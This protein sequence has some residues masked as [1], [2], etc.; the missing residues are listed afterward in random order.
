MIVYSDEF[1]CVW[2]QSILFRFTLILLKLK[3]AL[4][5]ADLVNQDPIKKV[6]LVYKKCLI[7]CY[8]RLS[9]QIIQSLLMR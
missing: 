5:T 4:I 8:K 6:M 1:I 7:R 2:Q 9:F 3:H